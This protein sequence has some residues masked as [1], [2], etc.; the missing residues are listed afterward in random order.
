LTELLIIESTFID[1]SRTEDFRAERLELVASLAENLTPKAS[2]PIATINSA[3]ILKDLI[4]NESEINSWKQMLTTVLEKIPDMLKCFA[5]GSSGG[6][7]ILTPIEEV[8]TALTTHSS[9]AKI[10]EFSDV[11]LVESFV[12]VLPAVA[13]LL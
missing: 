4:R 8:I 7:G 11:C 10:R 3:M 1:I 12:K 13:A 2:D 9:W 6:W 5:E